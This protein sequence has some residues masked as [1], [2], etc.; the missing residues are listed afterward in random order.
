MPAGLKRVYGQGHLHFLTFSCYR[1]LPLLQSV[2]ARDLFVKE[3]GKVREEFDF[4]LIGYVVMP[5]HVHLLM[6]EPRSGN[7][8]TVLHKLKSS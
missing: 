6:S 5:E 4:Q 7:P 2:R 8:S 1:R 3:L